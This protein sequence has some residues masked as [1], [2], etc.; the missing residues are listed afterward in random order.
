MGLES[1]GRSLVDSYFT[2]VLRPARFHSIEVNFPGLML[3]SQK[4]EGRRQGLGLRLIQSN[5]TYVAITV[6]KGQSASISMA[7]YTCLGALYHMPRR[8]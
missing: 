2:V 6:L 4:V 3:L 7:R 8:S 5:L 1:R